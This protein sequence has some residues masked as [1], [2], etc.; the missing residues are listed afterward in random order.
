MALELTGAGLGECIMARLDMDMSGDSG[1]RWGPAS[2][3][4]EGSVCRRSKRSR[5]ANTC[6]HNER[7]GVR[8]HDDRRHNGSGVAAWPWR[9]VSVC[10]KFL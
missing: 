6:A 1:T 5:Q 7:E 8:R 4:K 10:W 3:N 2:A 9:N